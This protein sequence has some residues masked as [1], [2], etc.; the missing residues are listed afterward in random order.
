MKESQRTTGSMPLWD[1]DE[2]EGKCVDGFR[3]HL[4]KYLV[5][6]TDARGAVLICPGGGYTGRAAHEGEPVARRFNEAGFHAFVVQY[7]VSPNRHPGPIRDAS[8]AMRMIRLHAEA[9][10]AS[11]N[12][13]AI[14][15]FS[16]G[17]HLA[18]SLGVH[19]GKDYLKSSCPVDSL[20]NR[21]DAMIL[22]YPVI[23]SGKFAHRGSFMNLLGRDASEDLLK[24]MS[25]E[26]QV[27]SD[28]PPAFLWHTQEDQGVP[29]ENSILFAQALRRH[30]I[31][32]E[33]HVYERG[34]HG[35]G[36][37]PED[38]HVA[39]WALLACQWLKLRGWPTG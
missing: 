20:S 18:A 38:E 2:A 35:L 3:P 7:R 8:R 16:A 4:E 23:T 32:F 28:T 6:S 39:T 21:P 14:C 19:F 27:R 17:G 10:K 30:G 34:R 37:A 13:V 12:H 29:V 36:L 15:G 33:L 22:C 25:L 5:D 24:Q 11:A 26:L 9:W 31:P 1:E